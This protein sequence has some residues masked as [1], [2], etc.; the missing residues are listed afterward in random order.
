MKNSFNNHQ[1]ISSETPAYIPAAIFLGLA[2]SIAVGSCIKEGIKPSQNSWF[3][4]RDNPESTSIE[5]TKDSP[6]ANTNSAAPLEAV[7]AP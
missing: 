6:A 1:S 7:P 2:L 4:K 3:F 5:S